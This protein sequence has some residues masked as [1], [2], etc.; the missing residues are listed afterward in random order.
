M[1]TVIKITN[2]QSNLRRARRS[3]TVMQQS[4]HWLQWDAPNSPPNF[5]FPS[6]IATRV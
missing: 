6:T 5:P 3:R 4:P 2:P 1:M